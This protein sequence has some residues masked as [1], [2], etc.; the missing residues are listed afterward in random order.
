MDHTIDFPHFEMV[1]ALD[2]V[3]FRIMFQ[4][5]FNKSCNLTRFY[6]VDCCVFLQCNV[7]MYFSMSL[8]LFRALFTYEGVT[9]N[10]KLT[11]SGGKT[12]NSSSFCYV[13]T[14]SP[15]LNKA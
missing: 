4:S 8:C 6:D 3:W 10:L 7:L 5:A 1:S 15:M 14:F 11:D 9:N 12:N 2:M 13:S